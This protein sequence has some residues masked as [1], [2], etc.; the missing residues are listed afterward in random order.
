M[1]GIGNFIG[2]L[3]GSEKAV[4]AAVQ[5]FSS[6]LDKLIYTKE[7]QADSARADTS[8]FRQ[9]MVEWFRNSQGQNLSRRLIALSI[10]FG[11]LSM[12]LISCLTHVAA[13]FV[14]AALAAQ[15]REAAGLIGENAE[16]LN[17]AV[18]IIIGFYFAAPHLGAIIKPAL[19]KFA[20][21]SAGKP[22]A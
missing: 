7:E 10:T 11:W 19:A 13:I 9:V 15:L 3:L 8:E 2:R 20:A 1:L 12:F 18:M 22:G 16:R 17:G 4:G 5:G 6:G 21:P 14:D